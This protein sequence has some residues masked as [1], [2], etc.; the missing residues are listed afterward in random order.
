MYRNLSSAAKT[1][2]NAAGFKNV[3][4]VDGECF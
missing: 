1:Y 4:I 2:R 3:V